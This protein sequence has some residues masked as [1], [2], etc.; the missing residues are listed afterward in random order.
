M[1]IPVRTA[2]S[3]LP[4]TGEHAGD[5]FGSAVA[6]FSDKDRTLLIVGAPTAGPKQ[7]GRT[8]VY[9][10]L[11]VKP[12]FIIEADESGSALGAMFLSVPGDVDGD[13]FPDVYASDWSNSAKGPMTGRV[14]CVYSGKDGHPLPNT[15]WRNCRRR[16][17]AR[18]H[19]LPATW[20][21][22]V[23]LISSWVPGSIKRRP[24]AAGA[25]I[26][27]PEKTAI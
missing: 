20:M 3:C 2:A 27:I 22:T 13:G 8:Y 10:S 25:H 21:V 7:T 16:L 6:G 24:S 17:R 4:L 19:R 14:Y 26:C 18:A 12:K 9:D 11:S 15:D 23:T 1:C 5:G